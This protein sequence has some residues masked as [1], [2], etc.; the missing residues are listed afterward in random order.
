MII[1]LIMKSKKRVVKIK[2]DVV[3]RERLLKTERSHRETFRTEYKSI[4][5]AWSEEIQ[6]IWNRTRTNSNPYLT[7]PLSLNFK[8]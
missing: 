6:S 2:L 1:F 7:T 4:W 8:F 3:N 5:A